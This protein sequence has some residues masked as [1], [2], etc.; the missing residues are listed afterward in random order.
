MLRQKLRRILVEE[1]LRSRFSKLLNILAVVGFLW[2]FS[3]PYIARKVFTSENALKV[4]GVDTYIGKDKL[5]LETFTR[6]K[7]EIEAIPSG[8]NRTQIL[9][10][11]VHDELSKN[12][13][14]YTQ[15][16]RTVDFGRSSNIYSYVRS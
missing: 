5:T 13:E 8:R 6:I 14:V 4:D 1:K 7:T 11:Y 16:L 12:G 10:E 9:H 2:I 15:P 3:G